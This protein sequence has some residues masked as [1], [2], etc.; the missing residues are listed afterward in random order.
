[1]PFSF[2]RCGFPLVRLPRL[3]LEAGLL[4]VTKVQLERFLAEPAGFGDGWYDR[5]LHLHSRCS[6][7]AFAA[8]ERE[9]LFLGGILPEEAVA[10]ASWLSEGFDLPT[11][12]EWRQLWLALAGEQPL[13][14]EEVAA[15][16]PGPARA[17]VEQLL[18]Q[19]PARSLLDL[20]LMRGG[21]VEWVREGAGWVGLGAPRPEFKAHLWDPLQDVVR[22]VQ[23]GER[24]GY[25]GFRLVR[26]M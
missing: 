3:R 5:V 6:Y 12:E 10:Y 7:R 23:A 4:P 17:I 8:A 2:D 13:G 20:S 16:R 1:M 25:F 15:W 11:V 24:V 18:A 26:R 21:L 14:A 19:L 22:P 9:R